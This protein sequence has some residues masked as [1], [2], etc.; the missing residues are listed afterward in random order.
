MDSMRRPDLNRLKQ[1]LDADPR[2]KQAI[3]FGSLA[4]GHAR[5]D[6]DLDLAVDV[7]RAMTV[8]ERLQRITR[9]GEWFGR[10]VDLIDLQ[11]VGEPLLGQILRHGVR[12]LGSNAQFARLIARH[13]SD[14]EDF[15]P[16][17]RRIMAQRRRAWIGM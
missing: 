4:N 16:L 11:T 12:L 8:D 15:L 3:A 10:P 6:S 7:G 13:F 14:S 1:Y 5:Y 17:Q 2:V 9:L